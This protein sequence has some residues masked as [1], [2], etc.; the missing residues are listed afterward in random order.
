MIDKNSAGKEKSTQ[1]FQTQIEQEAEEADMFSD[2][3]FEKL[4]DIS[5]NKEKNEKEEMHEM[6]SM[7]S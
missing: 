1:Y 6:I 7:A 2:N 4:G 5:D 3:K